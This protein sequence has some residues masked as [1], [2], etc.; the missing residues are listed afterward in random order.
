[1]IYCIAF[2]IKLEWVSLFSKVVNSYFYLDKKA[3]VPMK[4]TVA[5]CNF[6]FSDFER[7]ASRCCVLQRGVH[8][9]RCQE[10]VGR[11]PPKIWFFVNVDK[12]EK[13]NAV[14]FR[15]PFMLSITR[16]SLKNVVSVLLPDLP[17][18]SANLGFGFG[19]GPKPK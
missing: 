15:G 19:I 16:F 9:L 7:S 8:N 12:V 14:G 11:Y 3:S 5:F 1:M 6:F 2:E 4:H 13:V 18:V 17:K 10:E